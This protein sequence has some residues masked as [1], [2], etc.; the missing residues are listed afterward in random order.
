MT[1]TLALLV[2]LA[3]L[4]HATWNAIVKGGDDK[5]LS[6]TGLNLASAIICALLLPFLACLIPTAIP[7]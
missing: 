2:L 5:L 6:I 3:A 4:F 7:C 1:P